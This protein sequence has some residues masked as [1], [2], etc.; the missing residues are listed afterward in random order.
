MDAREGG[1][2]QY[3]DSQHFQHDI[4][5]SPL[6]ILVTDS[7]TSFFLFNA[8]VQNSSKKLI[9][10]SL[11][12]Q[13][14]YPNVKILNISGK[15]NISDFLSRLGFSKTSFFTRTLTPLS[16]NHEIRN[17]LPLF[18]TWKDVVEFYEKYPDLINFSKR[19]IDTSLQNN[20]YLDLTSLESS[21]NR[22]KLKSLKIFVNQSNFL[23]KF[24]SREKVIS[25]LMHA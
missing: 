23:D 11:K 24:Q 21:E 3:E 7:K 5:N 15:N 18:L 16:I 12:L 19:K 25:N 6:T 13:L 8:D 20:Y 2:P 22:T 14:S 17:K 9:R 4:K 1:R 10:W